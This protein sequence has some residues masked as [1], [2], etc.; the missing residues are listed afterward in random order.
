MP[1]VESVVQFLTTLIIFVFIVVICVLTTKFIGN[2]N[3]QQ[4]SGKSVK[5]VETIRVTNNKFIQLLAIGE[6]YLVIAVCKDQISVLS[7]L[8][9][10]EL[11]NLV[12]SEVSTTNADVSL[13]LK[14]SFGSILEKLKKK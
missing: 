10:E 5:V 11:P 13:A 3:K 1:N 7:Q 4:Y 12:L 6:V 2:F 8:T 9:K 14:E